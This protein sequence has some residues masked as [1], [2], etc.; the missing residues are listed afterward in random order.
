MNRQEIRHLDPGGGGGK[1][2]ATNGEP[3]PF[4]RMGPPTSTMPSAARRLRA[5]TPHPRNYSPLYPNP[6]TWSN[7]LISLAALERALSAER[8]SGYSTSSD[9]GEVDRV[10]RYLWNQS[11]CAAMQVGLHALEVTF[12][13]EMHRAGNRITKDMKFRT[14]AVASWLDAVPTMLLPHEEE[15]VTKATG[16]L[17]QSNRGLTEGRLVARLDFG[18]WVALCRAPYSDS[19]GNGP[20]LWPKAAEYVC[21]RRP[22]SDSPRADIHARMDMIRGYRNAIAH[23]E[24]IWDRNF[25][26]QHTMVIETLDWMSPGLANVV[27]A[28]SPALRVYAEGYEAYLEQAATILAKPIAGGMQVSVVD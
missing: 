25:L 8:L 6:A 11:L 17:R 16:F 20:R 14:G 3:H 4:D 22:P 15:K 2:V 13:N 12:R 21:T 10:A 19:R 23:H 7:P 1:G 5:G 18:F 26:H 9:A 28:Q 24:P 27:R